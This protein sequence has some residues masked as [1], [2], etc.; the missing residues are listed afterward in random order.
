LQHAFGRT[1]EAAKAKAHEHYINYGYNEKRSPDPWPGY[2]AEAQFCIDGDEWN[3]DNSCK[4]G[5]TVWYG[6]RNDENGNRITTWEKFRM[7]SA[8]P[9][10]NEAVYLRCNRYTF[11][12]QE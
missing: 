1:G 11:G 3:T 2:N 9:K 6:R 10:T 4:C 8:L 5:G 12:T 7:W